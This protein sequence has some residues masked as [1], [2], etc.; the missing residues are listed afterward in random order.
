MIRLFLSAQR[1]SMSVLVALLPCLIRRITSAKM[2]KIMSFTSIPVEPVR[3]V[4]KTLPSME[5]QGNLK[6]DKQAN[7]FAPIVAGPSVV[8]NVWM[9]LATQQNVSF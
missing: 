5:E 6:K 8:P 2:S 1:I 9:E 4:A 7:S 3:A